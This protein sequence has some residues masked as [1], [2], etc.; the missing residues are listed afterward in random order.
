MNELLSTLS[1]A[2]SGMR[3]QSIR[4]QRVTENVANADTPGYHRKLTEFQRA[5][6]A[7]DAI[8]TVVVAPPRLDLSDPKQI[9]DPANPLADENGYYQGSNVNL[10]VEIADAREAQRSYEANLKMFE[11]ARQMAEGLLGLL[12][13]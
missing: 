1:I 2:A 8:G 10:V 5:S 3:A 6:V 9:Y 7:A 4:L 13:R 12:R 11:Q